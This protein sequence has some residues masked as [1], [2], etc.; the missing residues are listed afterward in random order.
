MIWARRHLELHTTPFFLFQVFQPELRARSSQYMWVS[1]LLAV[2]TLH[3]TL[4]LCV[5]TGWPAALLQQLSMAPERV[6]LPGQL[7]LQLWGIAA[8]AQNTSP[9]NAPV[10]LPLHAWNPRKVASTDVF[11]ANNA[12]PTCWSQLAVL[13]QPSKAIRALLKDIELYS[14]TVAILECL[15][16]CWSGCSFL[17]ACLLVRK[18]TRGPLCSPSSASL[19][20]GQGTFISLYNNGVSCSKAAGTSPVNK[21]NP[22]SKHS[23]YVTISHPLLVDQPCPFLKVWGVW[24]MRWRL[25]GAF[26]VS[27][28]GLSAPVPESA[29]VWGSFCAGKEKGPWEPPGHN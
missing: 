16:S 27:W 11:L 21:P 12:I 29:P 4:G 24:V 6:W 14:G 28:F 25:A 5:R 26:K 1:P 23:V 8:A 3:L 19:S 10:I 13:Q 9:K 22:S 7:D 17:F 20:S 15:L 2:L 18:L